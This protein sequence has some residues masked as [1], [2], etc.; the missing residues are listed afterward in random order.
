MKKLLFILFSLCLIIGCSSDNAEVQQSSSSMKLLD[1]TFS[2]EK[3]GGTIRVEVRNVKTKPVC[4]VSEDAKNWIKE[5]QYAGSRVGDLLTYKFWY[6]IS[7]YD[8]YE[9]NRIGKI[10]I[11]CGQDKDVVEVSQTGGG[12]FAFIKGRLIKANADGGLVVLKPKGGFKVSNIKDVPVSWISI[13]KSITGSGEDLNVTVSANDLGNDRTVEICYEDAESGLSDKFTLLQGSRIVNSAKELFFD[14]NQQNASVS[15]SPALSV[16]AKTTMSW[17]TVDDAG[18][19]QI[20]ALPDGTNERSATLTFTNTKNGISESVN[21]KQVRSLAILNGNNEVQKLSLIPEYPF[22]LKA[23]TSIF[24][25]ST[26]LVW[27]SSN[28]S[29]VKVSPD[30]LITPV[31]EGKADITL[32]SGVYKKRCSIEVAKEIKGL[33]KFKY[34]GTLISEPKVYDQYK[35]VIRV[36]NES[37][38]IVT[39]LSVGGKAFEKTIQQAGSVDYPFEQRFEENGATS[40]LLKWKLKVGE[41]EADVSTYIK[42]GVIS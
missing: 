20:Q 27:S 17:A 42:A 3:E 11:T 39:I 34:E 28:E 33:I 38:Y 19:I 25:E 36:T 22:Q 7:E 32:S 13:D 26:P 14:E 31:G 37:S 12:P 15:I 29:V 5:G 1:K 23:L 8:G 4:E 18:K 16:E 21:V 35:G 41:K 6:N 40:H 2:V 9:T 10:S 24:T 30:G